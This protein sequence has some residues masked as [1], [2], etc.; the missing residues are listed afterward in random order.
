MMS[1]DW[2]NRLIRLAS[3][4]SRHMHAAANK[5]NPRTTCQRDCCLCIRAVVQQSQQQRRSFSAVSNVAL[6]CAET[7]EMRVFVTIE[8]RKPERIWRQKIY[9]SVRACACVHLFCSVSWSQWKRSK[10]RGIWCLPNRMSSSGTWMSFVM[11]VMYRIHG[12]L[13]KTVSCFCVWFRVGFKRLISFTH[14]WRL[15]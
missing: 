14:I 4:A 15:S 7:I 9:L 12:I 1:T 10:W 2:D 5:Q 3:G 6:F 11:Y 8:T 13:L